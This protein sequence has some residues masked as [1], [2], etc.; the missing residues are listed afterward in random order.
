MT[1]LVTP[2]KYTLAELAKV[3]RCS[4]QALRN[5]I[6]SGTLAAE[7]GVGGKWLVRAD[8]AHRHGWYAD[9]AGPGHDQVTS[10]RDDRVRELR[11]LYAETQ[12]QAAETMRLCAEMGQIIAE[13][14]E[15]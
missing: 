5:R 6:E 12:R 11:R 2:Q 4:T 1:A 13:M 7:R 15:G 10:A 14:D 8:E 3:A 9:D